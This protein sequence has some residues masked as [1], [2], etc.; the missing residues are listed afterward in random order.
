MKTKVT[1]DVNAKAVSRRVARNKVFGV[2]AAAE[3][4]RLITPYVPYETGNLAEDVTIEP[5]KITYNALYA[6][7]LYYGTS[8][9]FRKDK[10]ALASAKWNEAAKAIQK[11]KLIRALQ[12]KIE[13]ED[14]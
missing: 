11:P 9:N 10:H 6:R 8:F 7:R 5:N 3:W 13:K 2:F 12:R 1:V 14:I 4:F